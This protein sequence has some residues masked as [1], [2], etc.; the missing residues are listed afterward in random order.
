MQN[1]K[2][3]RITTEISRLKKLKINDKIVLDIEKKYCRIN[4]DRYFINLSHFLAINYLCLSVSFKD[5]TKKHYQKIIDKLYLDAIVKRIEI[6]Q[7]I[8]NI[9]VSIPDLD[10]KYLGIS[11]DIIGDI[12]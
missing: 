4:G 2:L 5:L 1:L 11:F 9:T 8:L 7:R 6:S 12:L 3:K 10:N